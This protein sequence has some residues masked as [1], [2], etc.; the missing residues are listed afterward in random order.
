MEKPL[1]SVVIP[2][3]RR[4]ELL[5][6]ACES[7]LTQSY[8][9]IE[10]VVVNDMPGDEVGSALE[11]MAVKIINN[12]KSLGGAGARNR[13]V[14]ESRGKFIAFLDDDDVFHPEKISRQVEVLTSQPEFGAVYTGFRLVDLKGNV[15]DV[16]KPSLCGN[17]HDETLCWNWVGT[18]STVMVRKEVLDEVGGFSPDLPAAQDWDLWIKI[19][20][21]HDFA[22]LPDPLIDFLAHSG[23]RISSNRKGRYVGYLTVSDKYRDK[24]CRLLKKLKAEHDYQVG[25]IFAK[26]RM[27]IPSA[28]RFVSAVIQH[29]PVSLKILRVLQRSIR[30]RFF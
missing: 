29:P 12:E 30:K 9:P 7:V 17:I 22:V 19:S 23:E 5:R 18:A 10:V 15:L 6:K 20:E 2:T 25:L 1:V 24:R 13:G 3:Y 11:G 27:T 21:K 26:S 8:S 28:K 16:K 14:E 4:H